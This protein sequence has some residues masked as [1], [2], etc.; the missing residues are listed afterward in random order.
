MRRK[1]SS[2][3]YNRAQW[4]SCRDPFFK[5]VV[6]EELDHREVLLQGCISTAWF[7]TLVQIAGHSDKHMLRRYRQLGGTQRTGPWQEAG[8]IS[9][10]GRRQ[11]RNSM[12]QYANQLVPERGLEPPLPCENCD[13]NA[14]R[15][16]IPPFGHRLHS[17]WPDFFQQ[18][19]P[20]RGVGASGNRS[21]AAK[22]VHCA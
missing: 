1:Q 21:A 14:A 3:A 12:P 19:I 4:V 2:P 13:L 6:V 9:F 18:R 22:N 15:L 20:R 11:A 8:S 17:T 7:P 5:Q 16:P 10:R